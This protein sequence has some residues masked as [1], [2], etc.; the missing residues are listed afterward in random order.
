MRACVSVS[1]TVR[2]YNCATLVLPFVF[3]TVF[4]FLWF[5]HSFFGFQRS[6]HSANLQQCL[7]ANLRV[8][9]VHSQENFM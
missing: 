3:F 9:S 1:Q 2:S 7:E 8:F 6:L 5:S 4:L